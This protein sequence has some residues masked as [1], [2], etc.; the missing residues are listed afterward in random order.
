LMGVVAFSHPPDT[1]SVVAR[2]DG[3]VLSK[4]EEADA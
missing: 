4:K 2:G 1:C 3:G